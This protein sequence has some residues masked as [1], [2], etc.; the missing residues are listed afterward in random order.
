[1]QQIRTTEDCGNIW[2]DI[3]QL[4]P[5]REPDLSVGIAAYGKRRKPVNETTTIPEVPQ[6]AASHAAS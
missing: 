6:D 2:S 3:H 4:R 1:M 5:D